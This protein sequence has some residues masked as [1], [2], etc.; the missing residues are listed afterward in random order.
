[1]TCIIS[2]AY[3]YKDFFVYR[4]VHFN[5]VYIIIPAAHYTLKVSSAPHAI[6]LGF[7]KRTTRKFS[8]N[9]LDRILV[10]V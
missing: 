6:I 5:I 1:M 3:F 9:F 2:N 10:S 7:S 4:I 8:L